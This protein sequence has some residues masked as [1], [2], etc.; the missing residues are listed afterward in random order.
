VKDV[1]IAELDLFEA[2]DDI[3][4]IVTIIDEPIADVESAIV[5]TA[6]VAEEWFWDTGANV[7]IAKS[8]K[9]LTNIR[10]SKAKIRGVGGAVTTITT[11]GDHPVIGVC[12]IL[13]G[14]PMN[15]VSQSQC[16][17]D[18]CSVKYDAAT[19]SFEVSKDSQTM[20]FTKNNRGLYSCSITDVA[21][22]TEH[23][24]PIHKSK[25]LD[26][27]KLEKSLGFPGDDA[28][29]KVI[30]G[31]GI[32]NLPITAEDYR[33]YR[34]ESGASIDAFKGKATAS[35]QSD[36]LRD[37][38]TKIG[39]NL[40]VDLFWIKGSKIK[41]PFLILKD[42][43]TGYVMIIDLMSKNTEAL[44]RGIKLG[45]VHMKSYNHRVRCIISDSE[46]NFKSTEPFLN[47]IKI[48]LDLR[49]PEV[50]SSLAE[51]GI[52]SIKDIARTVINNLQFRLP[53]KLLK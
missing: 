48:T 10:D 35:A 16:I 37:K 50:H 49:A 40:H 7:N 13:V 5:S 46:A 39:A 3:A 24:G 11:E 9:S 30:N 51:R 26:C 21:L 44:L 38:T 33:I 17:A 6:D 42:E 20:R 27:A 14:A 31:G 53:M 12:R 19:D 43:A 28:M 36:E 2:D 52:R 25:L 29:I 8:D 4:G 45:V 32:I 47:D 15:I 41:N 1:V 22:A 18:G 34:M 23:I